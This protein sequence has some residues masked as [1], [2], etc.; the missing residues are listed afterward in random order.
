MWR[1]RGV[2][3]AN[4]GAGAVRQVLAQRLTQHEH[5]PTWCPPCPQA[6]SAAQQAHHLLPSW[7]K[8]L[9]RMAEAH[10]ALGDYMAAAGAC[11][12]GERLCRP[13]SEG[14]TDLTPLLDR[15]AVV[16]AGVGSLV[17]YDGMQLEVRSAG[18]EA[19]LGGPASRVPE[20]DG[21][22]DEDSLLPAAMLPALPAG[23][24]SRGGGP[25]ISRGGGGGGGLA[26]VAQRG[27]QAAVSGDALAAWDYGQ[28]AGALQRRRTSFRSI[29]EAV[30]AAR[31]GDRILL[32]RGVHNGMG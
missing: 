11:K 32:R 31:D 4:E 24:T 8:P 20:L 23:P 30:A 29:K 3:V 7:P 6:M 21:P 9:H 2:V 17:G 13:D 26:L 28:T 18:E 10:L 27:G 14:H 1:C 19:W 16:A 12:A 5:A 15:V 22:E 25:T